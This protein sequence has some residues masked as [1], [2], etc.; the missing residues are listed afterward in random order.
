MT[1]YSNDILENFNEL[2]KKYLSRK[3]PG[4]DSDLCRKYLKQL[5]EIVK[6]LVN[7]NMYGTSIPTRDSKGQGK[8]IMPNEF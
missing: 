6:N 5:I 3:G 8:V 1:K 2:L 4:S 7:K